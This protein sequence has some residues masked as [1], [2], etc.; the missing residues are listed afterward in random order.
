MADEHGP[1]KNHDRKNFC[2]KFLDFEMEKKIREC[3]ISIHLDQEQEKKKG[4]SKWPL[5]KA[6][7]RFFIEITLR[8]IL[9]F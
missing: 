7:E 2:D 5:N 9:G 8:R 1:C 3:V 6:H 4:N